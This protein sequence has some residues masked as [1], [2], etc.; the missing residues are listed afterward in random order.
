ML[1]LAGKQWLED[2]HSKNPSLCSLCYEGKTLPN[3]LCPNQL[4]KHYKH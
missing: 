4:L 1:Q 2:Q 3:I